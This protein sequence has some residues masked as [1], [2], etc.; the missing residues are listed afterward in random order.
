MVNKCDLSSG[1]LQD[2]LTLAP[3]LALPIKYEGFTVICDASDVGLGC[4]L[5]QQGHVFICKR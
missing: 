3:V 2:F 5:M 1:K 4:F